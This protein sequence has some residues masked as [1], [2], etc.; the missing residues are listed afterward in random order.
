MKRPMLSGAPRNQECGEKKE[1]LI[2][3]RSPESGVA[4][5][6]RTRSHSD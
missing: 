3:V 4:K 2:L 6:V 1:G 5:F